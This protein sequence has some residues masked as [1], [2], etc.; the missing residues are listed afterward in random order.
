MPIHREFSSSRQRN[1]VPE[2]PPVIIPTFSGISSSSS[3]SG[4]KCGADIIN[5]RCCGDKGPAGCAVD[6]SLPTQ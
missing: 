5:R 2:A 4:S 1:R 3:S 6:P